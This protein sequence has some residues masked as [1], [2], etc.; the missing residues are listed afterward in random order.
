VSSRGLK[1]LA[2]LRKREDFL[3]AARQGKK[4]V[5]PGLI[6]QMGAARKDDTASQIRYGLTASGKVGIAVIR[7]RARRR[8]R[9]LAVE[10]LPPHAAPGRDYVLIARAATITRN[11]SDLREDLTIALRKLGAWHD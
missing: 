8:L 2:V 3:A 10:V 1:A 9:A 11:F 7:N 6:L 4:W 5:A